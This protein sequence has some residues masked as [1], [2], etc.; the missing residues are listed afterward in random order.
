MIK[1]QEYYNQNKDILTKESLFIMKEDLWDRLFI[2]D[3]TIIKEDKA[4]LIFYGILSKKDRKFFNIEN[5]F[6]VIDTAV[7]FFH[8]YDFINK[9]MIDVE[10][11]DLKVKWQQERLNKFRAIRKRYESKLRELDLVDKVMKRDFKYYNVDYLKNFA[12]L[13]F[14]NIIDYNHFDKAILNRLVQA[15]EKVELILQL[16]KNDFDEDKLSIS[17]FTFPDIDKNKLNIYSNGDQVVQLVNVLSEI[18][19]KNELSEIIDLDHEENSFENVISKQLIDFNSKP[20]FKETNLFQFLQELYNNLSR[21]EQQEENY[22][23]NLNQLLKSTHTN[24]FKDYYNLKEKDLRPLKKKSRDEYV[25]L[26]KDIIK[27]MANSKIDKIIADLKVLKNIES[28]EQLITFLKNLEIEKL[29]EVKYKGKDLEQYFDSLMEL[30]TIGLLDIDDNLKKDEEFADQLLKLVINY[31]E[32]K[33]VKIKE[34]KESIKAVVKKLDQTAYKK[35]DSLVMINV[36]Q[37]EI[38]RQY[39]NDTFLTEGDLKRLGLNIKETEHLQQKYNFFNHIFTSEKIDLYYFEN[40]E[41]NNTSSSFIE[42][43]KIECGLKESIPMYVEKDQK[44][45]INII[46]NTDALSRYKELFDNEILKE[47]KMLLNIEEDIPN[48]K[49]S[50]GHY[51]YQDLNRC[52]FKFYMEHIIEIEENNYDLDK[53]LGL[54]MIGI[55]AHEFFEEVIEEY[56]FPLE[57]QYREKI[58]NLLKNKLEKYH[59][60]IHDYFKKYYNDIL[61]ES[62]IDSIYELD[63][64]IK[65]KIGEFTNI[66]SEVSL[67]KRDIYKNK[68]EVLV[69]ISGRPDLLIENEN[70]SNYIIDLKTG[71]GSMEQLALY[72]LMLNYDDRDFSK[73]T[74]AIYRI[75]D[76]QLSIS[77]KNMEEKLEEK[78]VEELDNLFKEKIYKKI[79]KSDCK[80]CGNYDICRVV[81]K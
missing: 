78:I 48:K 74:K 45:I 8:F 79:Y 65:N 27:D 6:D 19:D 63:R 17:S 7:E 34:D 22:H 81:I 49:L 4:N 14:V 62:L 76:N 69:Y 15:G 18:E 80:D 67:E 38:P 55:I 11:L 56:G 16:N 37:G 75:M 58:R 50:M 2:T 10:E 39:D 12:K 41:N 25:Y 30:E 35:R 64:S 21:Y 26:N 53:E 60:Q 13:N 20:S 44:E 71:K 9:N 54:R 32:F 59:L 24:S 33:K 52:P 5:Y 1:A 72:S 29:K 28:M 73:T 40:I 51:K 66:E 3:K 23:L 42:E 68:E 61:F 57:N 77:N 46:F 70:E 36:N 31:M 43:L 47:D